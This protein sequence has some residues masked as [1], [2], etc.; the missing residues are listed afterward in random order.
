MGRR[1]DSLHFGSLL[2][3]SLKSLSFLMMNLVSGIRNRA[4]PPPLSIHDAYHQ[5]HNTKSRLG[6]KHFTAGWGQGGF[7]LFT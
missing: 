7:K 1:V 6:L 2:F 4:G 3:F 5:R